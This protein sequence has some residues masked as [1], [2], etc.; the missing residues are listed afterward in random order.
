MGY[1]E[2]PRKLEIGDYNVGFAGHCPVVPRSK[3]RN[4]QGWGWSRVASDKN[5]V[6]LPN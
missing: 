1:D 2:Q 5:P 3:R 6:G 4:N